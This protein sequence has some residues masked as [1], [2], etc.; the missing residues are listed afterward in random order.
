MHLKNH[1]TG[2]LMKFYWG[3]EV[4]INAHVN[5]AMLNQKLG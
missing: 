3:T 1:F 4:E 2:I 5:S